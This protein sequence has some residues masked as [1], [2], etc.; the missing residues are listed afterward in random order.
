VIPDGPEDP[1]S[2]V[3]D[4]FIAA[5]RKAWNPNDVV[6]PP[7]GGGTTNVRFFA[8]DDAKAFVDLALGPNCKEP[9]LWVRAGERYRSRAREFPNPIRGNFQ[10]GN[11]DVFD[12]LTVEVGVARCVSMDER[13]NWDRLD[14]EAE[15]SLSDSWR[16]SL[17]LCDA[18]RV[19]A[20]P[21]RAF[22][23]DTVA[24][25]GPEGGIVCWTGVAFVQLK[26]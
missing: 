24:A 5:M 19:L 21:E 15:I 20:R 3:V 9:F 23:T 22:A 10:C 16:I 7:L 25:Y 1:A 8:G 6:M 4:T 14:S 11:K 13:P 12:V 17:A 2:I 18:Q 26:G